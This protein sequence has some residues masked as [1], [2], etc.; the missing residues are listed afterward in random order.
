MEY[1]KLL[2]RQMY[3]Y[4]THEWAFKL[5]VSW[6]LVL[7]SL[8]QKSTNFII[9]WVTMHKIPYSLKV[10]IIDMSYQPFNILG[11]TNTQVLL[12]EKQLTIQVIHTLIVQSVDPLTSL[13]SDKWRHL[14][15]LECPVSV[16]ADHARFVFIFHTYND[17]P[18]P[19]V[20]EL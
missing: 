6:V 13:L 11:I 16:W 1:L 19:L 7:T 5:T 17:I 10:L 2:E 15:V 20:K 4:L 12:R 14:T 3:R 8:H 18:L 9:S